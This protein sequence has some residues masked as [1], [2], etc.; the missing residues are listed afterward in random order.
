MSLC[1]C[2]LVFWL[3]LLLFRGFVVVVVNIFRS[4]RRTQRHSYTNI[5]WSGGG[6]YLKG[7]IFKYS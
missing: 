4:A 7:N 3:L 1:V 5:I 2:L 6:G